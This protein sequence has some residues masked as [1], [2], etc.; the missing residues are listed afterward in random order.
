MF[1]VLLLLILFYRV[2]H[3]G[4]TFVIFHLWSS[5]EIHYILR[6]IMLQRTK[7]INI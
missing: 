7:D 3:Q 4:K 2:D 6:D 1:H 5:S